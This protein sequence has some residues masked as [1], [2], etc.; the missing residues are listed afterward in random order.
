MLIHSLIMQTKKRL[1]RD[2][3][4]LMLLSNILSLVNDVI[5]TP[6]WGQNGRTYGRDFVDF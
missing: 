6:C 2:V 4:Y 1:A 5:G 3:T